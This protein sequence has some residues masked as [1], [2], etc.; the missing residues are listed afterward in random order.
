MVVRLGGRPQKP[1]LGVKGISLFELTDPI[2]TT[3]TGLFFR[4][5]LHCR[6]YSSVQR[7]IYLNFL[8]KDFKGIFIL[9]KG[10]SGSF[11]TLLRGVTPTKVSWHLSLRTSGEA[12]V[13]YDPSLLKRRKEKNMSP[14]LFHSWSQSRS[15]T[16]INQVKPQNV[17]YTCGN[18]RHRPSV[19]L[20][21]VGGGGLTRGTTM[22]RGTPTCPVVYL[23]PFH[24]STGK[25]PTVSRHPEVECHL[26][27]V[28]ERNVRTTLF[29]ETTTSGTS[30]LGVKELTSGGRR[31]VVF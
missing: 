10:T 1:R 24:P 28:S 26:N 13:L 7:S 30:F 12:D 8:E 29:F 22:E 3:T 11:R 5:R 6:R 17:L 2:K 31:S 21:V 25:S 18:G 19:I 23:T 4:E 16:M 15:Q 27:T 20:V 9:L 14:S